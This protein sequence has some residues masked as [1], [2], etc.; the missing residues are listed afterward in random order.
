MD[1]LQKEGI[2]KAK[3]PDFGLSQS[4]YSELMKWVKISGADGR[5]A[6]N[7]LATEK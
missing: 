1:N 6:A 7:A 3:N 4:E 5:E 2:R